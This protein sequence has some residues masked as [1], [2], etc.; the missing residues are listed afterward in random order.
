MTNTYE[1]DEDGAKMRYIRDPDLHELATHLRDS[2]RSYN[3]MIEERKKLTKWKRNTRNLKKIQNLSNNIS[4]LKDEIES[5]KKEYSDAVHKIIYGSR[6]NR[7]RKIEEMSDKLR[8]SQ[9]LIQSTWDISDDIRSRL[10]NQIMRIEDM[11]DEWIELLTF[12]YW[13]MGIFSDQFEHHHLIP[14]RIDDI[15]VVDSIFR[16][17]QMNMEELQDLWNEERIHNATPTMDPSVYTIFLRVEEEGE[18]VPDLPGL[19]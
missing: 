13:K 5:L 7:F 14:I 4:D 8:T 19:D 10:E 17:I 18:D 3:S 11:I 16:Q 2:V 1:L 6:A 15:E 9:L 12:E